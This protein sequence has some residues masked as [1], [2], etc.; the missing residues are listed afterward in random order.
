MDFFNMKNL[1]ILILLF[2]LVIF[3]CSNNIQPNLP[4]TQDPQPKSQDN[5]VQNTQ[6]QQD[7]LGNTMPCCGNG[8]STEELL[9]HNTKTDCWVAYKG[10]VYDITSWLP[11]HPGTSSAIEPYCGSS[12]KFEEAFTKKHGTTKA[13]LLMKVGVFM[14]DFKVIDMGMH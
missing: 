1:M 7:S 11:R 2:A 4:V 13:S 12:S 3:G 8:V 9:K 5:L 10:K 6:D 14:G